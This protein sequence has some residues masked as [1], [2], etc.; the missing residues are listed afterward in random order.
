[1]S[2]ASGGLTRAWSYGPRPGPQ[3]MRNRL[4]KSFSLNKS[5]HIFLLPGPN[6]KA[7]RT[8]ASSLPTR[9]PRMGRHAKENIWKTIVGGMGEGGWGAAT[10]RRAFCLDFL[11]IVELLVEFY[12]LGWMFRLI[13]ECLSFSMLYFSEC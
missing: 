5:F 3:S 12:T 8:Y 13:W 7:T 1:M 9:P 10:H 2:H 4:Q 6:P 11:G